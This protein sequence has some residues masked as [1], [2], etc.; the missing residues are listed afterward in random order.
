MTS[1]TS[2]TMEALKVKPARLARRRSADLGAVRG[3]LNDPL[4]TKLGTTSEALIRQQPPNRVDVGV[5]VDARIDSPRV[6]RR[7]VHPN[8]DL[9]R[10][11]T[12][13]LA[14]LLDGALGLALLEVDLSLFGGRRLEFRCARPRGRH[15]CLAQ[16]ACCREDHAAPMASHF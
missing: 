15:Q 5:D 11:Q 10:N 14:Q 16:H 13:V 4:E 6:A 2:T 8:D 7:R 9:A 12:H 1:V 3:E